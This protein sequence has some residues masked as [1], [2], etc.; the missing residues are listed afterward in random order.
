MLIMVLD[1]SLTQSKVCSAA[2]DCANSATDGTLICELGFL[3]CS[4]FHSGLG[5]VVLTS[6]QMSIQGTSPAGTVSRKGFP[7]IRVHLN[8]FHITLTDVLESQVVQ[9][10]SFQLLALRTGG[11]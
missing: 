4:H 2:Y 11:L 8:G 10:F 1:S 9:C 6:L 3:A 7:V 5:Q